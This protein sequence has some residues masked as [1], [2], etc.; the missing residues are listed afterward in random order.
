MKIFHL[1]TYFIGNK[2]YQKLFSNI[3]KNKNICQEVYVPIKDKRLEGKNYFSDKTVNFYYDPILQKK[4]RLMYKTKIKKQLNRVEFFCDNLSSLNL[5][6]AHTLYSDGG[7]AYLLKRKY[8]IKYIL[9][10]RGTDINIFYKYFIHYRNFI[11]KV[12]EE[13]EVIIFISEAYKRKVS[14][15]L[16]DEIKRK[17]SSK[18]VVIPNGIDDDW[19]EDRTIFKKNPKSDKTKLM[20][21]GTLYPNKNLYTVLKVLRELNKDG[22]KYTLDVAGDGPSKNKLKNY[23]M[24]NSLSDEVF[25]HGNLSKGE[26]QN[27]IANTDIFILPS[28]HETFGISYIEAM[29]KGLPIIYTENEGI[30][31]F[32][33]QGQVGYSVH[34]LNVEDIV[35]KVKLIEKNYKEISVQSYKQSES[36][37]WSKITQM[38]L[39]LYNNI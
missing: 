6:H 32:F 3:A 5:I 38:Y 15:I 37:S 14:N 18:F 19:F 34:P 36:F 35:Q 16:P 21:T 25:F 29:S 4:D 23:V 1:C 22:I 31:G 27:V 39:D 10:V 17:V 26:L 11:Y 13:A 28:I 8:G 24:Q 20:F 33:E 9:S 12:L 30:D 2:L 7:T